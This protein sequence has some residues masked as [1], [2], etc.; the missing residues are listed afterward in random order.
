MLERT[1]KRKRRTKLGVFT[2]LQNL[3]LKSLLKTTRTRAVTLLKF[4]AN[5]FFKQ[6]F[7]PNPNPSTIL[8]FRFNLGPTIQPTIIPLSLFGSRE[9]RDGKS[10]E[11]LDFR[12][13]P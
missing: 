10:V 1:L 11:F 3:S 9:S 4:V 12:A 5:D 7:R 2:L 8:F 13:F 6:R